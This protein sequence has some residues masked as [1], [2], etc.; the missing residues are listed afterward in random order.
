MLDLIEQHRAE[1]SDLC[2]KYGVKSLEL[3]GS[4]ARGDFEPAKSDL[5]FL[6]QLEDQGW[7]GL[8]KRYFGLLH[9]LEDLFHRRIDLVER[10]AVENPL[11]L[12]VAERHRELLYAA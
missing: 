9:G 6:V 2:R 4:A 1:L 12:E 11:F 3:I 7:E 5:D 10:D 8:S